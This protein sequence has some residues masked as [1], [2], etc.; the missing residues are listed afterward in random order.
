MLVGILIKKDEILNKERIFFKEAFSNFIRSVLGKKYHPFA[1]EIKPYIITAMEENSKV[2]NANCKRFFSRSNKI[3][4]P[5]VKSS[6]YRVGRISIARHRKI[7]SLRDKV[8]LPSDVLF[9][10][11]IS[12]P[13]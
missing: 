1:T 3:T 12:K 11:S 4:P 2:K 7:I 5:I 6:S 13:K 8:F 9:S 10:V